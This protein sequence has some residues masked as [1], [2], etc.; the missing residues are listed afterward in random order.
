MLTLVRWRLIIVFGCILFAS[1]PAYGC[2]ACTAAC[3]DIGLCLHVRGSGYSSCDIACGCP[4][5]NLDCFVTVAGQAAM[6][7]PCSETPNVA[8]RSSLR[9]ETTLGLTVTKHSTVVTVQNVLRGSPA[10]LAGVRVGDRIVEIDG[11]NVSGMPY[12]QV[13]STLDGSDRHDVSLVLHRHG[14]RAYTLSPRTVT[15][16]NN[17]IAEQEALSAKVVKIPM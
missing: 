12:G 9:P 17:S 4:V 16:I 11:K 15:A 13:S 2:V 1:W 5:Q 10:F 7:K 8:Q 3:P 6:V 14:N